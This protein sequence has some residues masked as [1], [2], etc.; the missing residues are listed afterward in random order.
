MRFATITRLVVAFCCASLFVAASQR[1]S[2]AP[3]ATRPRA[4]D[5]ERFGIA[6]FKVT[7]DRDGL[8]QNSVKAMAIDTR[9]YL[10]TGTQDGAAFY[11]G[12]T[13]QVVNMP[14][15][16]TS[17]WVNTIHVA[18]DGALL[19]GTNGAGIARL[20]D[21]VWTA[22]DPPLS[23]TR[24]RFV[25]D[26]A[27]AP[28]RNGSVT[29]WVAASDGIFKLENGAWTRYGKDSGLPADEFTSLLVARDSA[30]NATIWAGS[31]AGVL[32]YAS[33]TWLTDRAADGLPDPYVYCLAAGP[34]TVWAGTDAGLA[35]YSSGR[36]EFV[37]IPDVPL[38]PAVYSLLVTTDPFGASV[39]WIGS[40]AGLA[41][42]Q[43]DRWQSY[44]TSS[45]L[46][47]N[48]VI[49]LLA[50]PADHGVPAV[51]VGTLSGG[52]AWLS[53]GCWLAFDT[54]TGLPDDHVYSF[55]ETR[56]DSG[57]PVY[58]IGTYGGLARF[59]DAWWTIYR[60]DS[61]LPS[62]KI[63]C[64][65][66]TR[67]DSGARVMWVGT[68]GGL[69]RFESGRWTVIDSKSGLPNNIVRCVLETGSPAGGRT[70]WVGTYGGVARFDGATWTVVDTSSGL[71]DNQV[72]ALAETRSPAGGT[73][74]WAGTLGGGLARFRDGAWSTIDTTSGLPN[75]F[76]RGLREI[77][78]PDGSRSLWVGTLGGAAWLD[79]DH[80]E[81]GWHVL[82]DTT[83][84]ALPNSVIYDIRQDAH[85]QIYLSTNKGV[86]RLTRRDPSGENASRFDLYNFT[87]ED[88]LPGNECNGG[89]LM[90]DSSG[91]I[92][93]GTVD[94]AGLFDPE[95]AVAFRAAAPL[96]IERTLVNGV[97]A[98]G[99]QSGEAA[100]AGAVGVGDHGPV[101]S[102]IAGRSLPHGDNNVTFEFA[103]LSYFKES[104]TR[105]RTQ[106]VG[107]DPEP[108]AWSTD[109]S[110]TY[111]R[112]PEGDF[113]FKVWGRDFAGN[114]VGPVEVP[115]SIRAAPWR[116]YWAYAL[117]VALLLGL[118]Y[119]IL[120]LRVR[121][122]ERRN[123]MLE[124]RIAERTR[125]LD[126]KNH[127]LA[128]AIEKLVA[129]ERQAIE[130]N[131]AKSTFLAN[132]SHELRTPLN[133]ILG[134][135]QLMQRRRASE[136]TEREYLEIITRSGEHLLGL[137]N[138]VLSVA[139]I[140]SGK[141]TLTE[142]VF[143]VDDMLRNLEVMLSSRAREK[144]I[145]LVVERPGKIPSHVL[146]DEGKLR[147]ILI[148]LI[149]NAIKFTDAG[150]VT[151]RMR[152]ADGVAEF[153][154][155][156]TGHGIARDELD[157]LFE[158]FVQTESGRRSS[159]GSGLGLAISRDFVRLMGGELTAESDIGKGTRFRFHV[160]LPEAAAESR[161]THRTV[162]GLEPDSASRRILV[163]DDKPENRRLLVDLLGPLGF[164]LREA[165]NGREAI[166]EHNRW[167]PDV[168]LIDVRMPVVDGYEAT[169]RIRDAERSSDPSRHSAI[170][171]LSA[172][173]F[174]HDRATIL[175][176]GCD[177][178]LPKPVVAVDLLA[179]LA[180][181]AGVKFRYAANDE[182]GASEHDASVLSLARLAEVPAPLRAELEQA[183]QDG[184]VQRATVAVGAIRA[185]DEALADA[186]LD[187]VR[188]YRFD[189]VLALLERADEQ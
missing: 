77:D 125:E 24:A 163:V 57:L 172:S 170:I 43:N 61:G 111:T 165:A 67:A 11:N 182:P 84:P 63:N 136:E 128:E 8:P 64:L 50:T 42:F 49:S 144:G 21:G 141:T 169:R 122:F 17:N 139:K 105:Y 162:L 46:P 130:A 187:V 135:V 91:R 106:L 78:A 6:S 95:T 178:F 2:T 76:V 79:L 62:D 151:V 38:Q 175:E 173:V 156:D 177:E 68:Q 75:D 25:N 5:V 71:H 183:L 74:I 53:E 73:T 102:T 186:L 16:K 28:G 179:A 36:W 34:Q 143:E 132:M 13:W 37:E 59:E 185:H 100:H 39:V 90:A 10:W 54:R 158:P 115:F 110:R 148:N 44:G 127:A 81:S 108:S 19:F 3:H 99:A 147:Q 153:D 65:L 60:T 123:R 137:I 4:D 120:R 140:E 121:Q 51:L 180:T 32:R 116:T 166:D 88:G 133:A 134:F 72:M 41:R 146:G 22:L 149:G 18:S 35:R 124:E 80:E 101:A 119:L 89:A 154:V 94:G 107:F 145:D 92:W 112:L 168:I 93:V 184:D 15:R 14:D 118:G 1:P 160:P 29:L 47:D 103:L 164:E 188:T 30:G 152:W 69:A 114:V 70:L 161:A 82:S 58:W 126:E 33:G 109:P 176:A 52:L 159:E 9:G 96:L 31:E 27:E 85:G 189:E 104:D 138:D 66:E 12:R 150:S 98:T 23:D 129:S 48:S 7:S 167:A 131:R 86:V 97:V 171:A 142:A 40:A 117:Y 87:T 55:L 113:T 174:D 45:G 157:R 181:H 20:K 83:E 26:I 56:A 155:D